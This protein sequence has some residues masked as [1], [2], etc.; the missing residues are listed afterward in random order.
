MPHRPL[1]PRP[2]SQ[3]GARSARTRWLLAAVGLLVTVGAIVGLLGL[4]SPAEAHSLES[5][6][7][8]VTITDDAVE[9]GLSIAAEPLAQAMGADFGDA[10]SPAEITAHADEIVAYLDAHLRVTSTDGTT[11]GE[12]Y[13]DPDVAR[14]E[15][16]IVVS[17]N[18]GFETEDS[19]ITRFT[20]EYDAVTDSVPDHEAVLV[21]RDSN[22]EIS[23]VGIFDADNTTLV[24]T[25]GSHSPPMIDMIVYGFDH[26]L[27]GADHLLF[28]TTLLLPAP[29]IVADRRWRRGEGAR[30]TLNKV[31]HVITAFTLG[32]S[33]T[34][35]ASTLGWISLPSRP[36]EVLIAISVAISAA[37][38][39]RPLIGR[40][41]E[42]IA[43][44]FGL[45][46][47]LAFA[48]ILSDL[49]LTGTTSALNLLAFNLGIELSQ[50][51]TAAAIFPSLYALSLTRFYPSVRIVGAV[52]AL[53]AAAAWALD[54]LEV[55]AN[56]LSGLEEAAISHPWRVVIGLGALAVVLVGL[57]RR[58]PSTPAPRQPVAS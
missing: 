5:S 41:E 16:I 39:I 45:I 18:V 42:L 51:A 19:T 48:G 40:G 35:V 7:V 52:A 49:G 22:R 32:H 43:G 2:P 28:L 21:L 14:I 29:L 8:V 15:G 6:T 26:V 47:G 25:D 53:V 31:F 57:D 54:R 34:L 24:V 44:G 12:D 46:H 38:A 17:V 23:S 50:L 3:T 1:T 36:V 30:P 11:W 33:L 4:P 56:P 20:V 13:D 37:H 55:L 58:L 9:A 10:K 27:E